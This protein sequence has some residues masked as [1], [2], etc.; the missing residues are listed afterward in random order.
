MLV[1]GVIAGSVLSSFV[2]SNAAMAAEF[3]RQEESTFELQALNDLKAWLTAQKTSPDPFLTRAFLSRNMID[4][5]LKAFEGAK[6]ELP[7]YQVIIT[8]GNVRTDFRPALP[9]LSIEATAER[10][11]VQ[12]DVSTV[13]HIEPVFSNEELH[14][15]IHVDS[16]E[17]RFSSRFVGIAFEGLARDLAQRK[18][19]DAINK[20]DALG[21][22]SIPLSQT[23]VFSLPAAEMPFQTTGLKAMATL[24]ALSGSV[25]ARLVRIVAM[26]EGIYVY[27]TL[28]VEAR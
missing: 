28:D 3:Q 17:P 24:P 14:L 25:K 6:V 15:R 5:I 11:G 16:L 10:S 22:I 20:A 26:P 9:G 2:C 1:A 8:I 13:A 12:I 7:D 23:Q 27:A 19:I 18:V 4:G 21:D